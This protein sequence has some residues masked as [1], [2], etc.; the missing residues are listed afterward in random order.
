[1]LAAAKLRLKLLVAGGIEFLLRNVT[2]HGQR[3]LRN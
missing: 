1:M 3:L 2:H